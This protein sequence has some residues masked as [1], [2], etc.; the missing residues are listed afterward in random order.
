MYQGA[1]LVDLHDSHKSPNV[2]LKDTSQDQAQ[3]AIRTSVGYLVVCNRKFLLKLVAAVRQTEEE[4]TTS[5]VC[6]HTIL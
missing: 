5:L 6:T 4:F 3:F 1:I 2:S